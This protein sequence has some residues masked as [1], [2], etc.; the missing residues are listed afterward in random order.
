MG[1]RVR[2]VQFYTQA[3]QERDNPQPGRD[4]T[5]PYTLLSSSVVADPS[6]GVGW[7]ELANANADNFWRAAAVAANRRALE[8]PDGPDGGDMT[9]EL[10]LKA[11]SNL[12]HHL[13]HLGQHED[14]KELAKKVIAK[15]PTLANAWATL[16]MVYNVEGRMQKAI[17]H[18]EKAYSLDKSCQVEMVL[19]FAHMHARNLKEGLQHFEARYEY[20]LRHFLTYPYPK[21]Q[22]E[23]GKVLFVMTDQGMGDVISFSRFLPAAIERSAHVHI[24]VQPEVVK[25]LQLQLQKYWQKIT[26]E[27]VPCPYPAADCWTTPMSI[28]TALGLSTAEILNTPALPVIA[29]LTQPTWKVE[30]RKLHIG[31]TWTGSKANWINKERTFPFE[32]LLELYRV[33][34]IHLYSLQIDNGQQGDPSLDIPNAGAASL[35]TDLR[36]YIREVTD[37]LGVLNHLDMVITCE[38]ALGHI[39]GLANKECWIPYSYSGGDFRIGRTEQGS[40]WYP[41]HRI[42]RQNRED[43]GWDTVFKRIVRALEK[44]VKDA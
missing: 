39:A 16:A 37:T 25:L 29:P 28:P 15:D 3:Q 23:E 11:M 7:Y 30:G 13:H 40:I 26:I 14:A 33:P 34:G 38:S 18:A 44:R 17:E 35:V 24:R 41:K 20:I 12:A 27:P 32:K 31:V 8:L 1:D 4:P 42:F 10:R 36:P 22:G 6:F 9:D 19:A 5:H 21:W 43:E 2:A